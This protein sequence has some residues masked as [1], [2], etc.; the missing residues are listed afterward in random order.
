MSVKGLVNPNGMNKSPMRQLE[1]SI[2]ECLLRIGRFLFIT[3]PI[4]ATH[5]TT[6]CIGYLP[7]IEKDQKAGTIMVHKR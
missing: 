3:V 2:D 4:H 5:D 7:L 1:L 6:A